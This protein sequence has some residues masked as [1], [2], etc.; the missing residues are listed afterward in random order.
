MSLLSLA[1]VCDYLEENWPSMDL[2]GDMLLKHLQK[3]YRDTLAATRICPPMRRRLTSKGQR[4]KG[5]EQSANGEGESAKG[6]EE[7]GRR[8]NADRFLNRFWDYPRY[9]RGLRGEFDLFHLVDHSY[10]QLLHVLPAERTI[11]TCHD[12]DTFQC[13]LNPEQEPRSIYFRKMMERTLSGFRKAAF[14]T[15]DSVATQDELL[16]YDLIPLERTVVIPNGVHPSCSP[17][18]NAIAD[19]EVD[20]LMG[21]SQ[22]SEVRSQELEAR[23]GQNFELRI[24]DCEIEEQSVEGEEGIEI[25]HVGSTI[26]RKRIDILLRVFASVKDAFPSA[27]LI[28]VGGAFTDEQRNLVDKLTLAESIL[29]VPYIERDVLAA[30]YRRATMVLMPS[31]REG[32]GLPIVEAMACGTPVIASDLKVLREVGGDVATYCPVADVQAW[33]EKVLELVEERRDQRSEVRSQRAEVRY[34]DSWT[35]RRKA[36]LAQAA[37]FSWA[38]YARKMVGVYE[39]VLS[40]RQSAISNQHSRRRQT[41]E[42]R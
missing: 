27:R 18:P 3:N 20:R 19:A 11:V 29:V 37:Q 22:K 34:S 40:C 10:G 5:K 6:E 16:A 7:R 17:E 31:E 41:S 15:C 26:P 8:F 24:S 25:L 32:F 39:K 21:R 23:T 42:I 14:V 13:L 1:V 28:R 38:E 12:L 36:G 2:V 30:V 4:A 35:R 33:S 9:L